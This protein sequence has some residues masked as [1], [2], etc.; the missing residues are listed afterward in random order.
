MKIISDISCFS[1]NNEFQNTNSIYKDE[2]VTLTNNL[3]KILDEYENF[4]IEMYG[5]DFDFP[6]GKPVLIKKSKLKD[7]YHLDMFFKALDVDNE[8]K[9][10][11]NNY[12]EKID[13][14]IIYILYNSIIQRYY[15]AINLVRFLKQ[16]KSTKT[17]SL[18][19]AY[20]TE[21]KE[22][23][24]NS[25]IFTLPEKA[26]SYITNE[27]ISTS[28]RNMI[29]DYTNLKNEQS[30]L[31]SSISELQRSIEQYMRLMKKEKLSI[32]EL[33]VYRDILL[34]ISDKLVIKENTKQKRI[35]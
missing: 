20:N 34:G 23:I 24:I 13:L 29:I 14:N 8:L 26:L 35:G 10:K 27:N 30:E 6:T 18:F 1:I 32:E 16:S 21:Y 7:K 28:C 19:T 5:Y 11:Y 31:L 22:R 3:K 9:E 25:T 33:K 12:G 4:C 15:D 2:I 17:N